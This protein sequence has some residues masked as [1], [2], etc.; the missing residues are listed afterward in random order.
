MKKSLKIRGKNE[1]N[2]LKRNESKYLSVDCEQRLR[3]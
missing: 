2:D 3:K 1:N